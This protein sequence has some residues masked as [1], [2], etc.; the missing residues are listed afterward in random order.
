[1]SPFFH[2]RNLLRTGSM[3]SIHKFSKSSFSADFKN[4]AP[5][6]I[7]SDNMSSGE[8]GLEMM[9]TFFIQEIAMHIQSRGG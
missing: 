2:F 3:H 1:M 6:I 9:S 8:L 7:T 4:T 5:Y